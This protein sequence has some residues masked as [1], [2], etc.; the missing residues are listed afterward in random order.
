MSLHDR[1][2]VKSDNHFQFGLGASL[3]CIRHSQRVRYCI[4]K[5][6]C[7]G[8]TAVPSCLRITSGSYPAAVIQQ[9]PRFIMIMANNLSQIHDSVNN[10]AKSNMCLDLSL[11]TMMLWL[12]SPET[13]QSSDGDEKEVIDGFFRNATRIVLDNSSA[14]VRPNLNK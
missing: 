12:D 3:E 10:Q 8:I 11:S 2:D 5:G 7:K 1:N 4:P 14:P 9:N 13:L 6:T